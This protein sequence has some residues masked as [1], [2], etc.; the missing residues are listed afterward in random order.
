MLA[1]FYHEHSISDVYLGFRNIEK[2]IYFD[3]TDHWLQNFPTTT[4]SLNCTLAISQ[5]HLIS[6]C[7]CMCLPC[8]LTILQSRMDNKKDLSPND[9]RFHLQSTHTHS[10]PSPINDFYDLVCIKNCIY[11]FIL[12]LRSFC[13]VLFL[14]SQFCSLQKKASLYLQFKP[15]DILL[16]AMRKGNSFH[17][18]DT[19]MNFCT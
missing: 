7:L 13:S 19:N 16:C 10:S 8:I 12:I 9:H 14:I 15:P 11:A 1:R 17:A 18:S 2:L 6:F 5:T 3:L 4:L